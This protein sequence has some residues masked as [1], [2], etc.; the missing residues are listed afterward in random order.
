M[1]QTNFRS[2]SA[3][4]VLCITLMFTTNV[5]A[6]Q[7]FRDSLEQAQTLIR[8]GVR[9]ILQEELLLTEEENEAFWPLYDEYG[10]ELA[11]VSESY[12][13]VMSEFVDR[14]QTG[15]LDDKSADRLLDDSLE[16]QM[17]VMEVRRN[18]VPRFREIL[19]GVK[20]VRFYQLENKVRAEVDAALALAIPLADPR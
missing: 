15:E 20:V 8:S 7:S 5:D 9:Q 4:V 17:S 18:Y 19:S 1:S 6:Q 12:V 16:I 2:T 13:S 3:A 10:A 14:Y 11:K